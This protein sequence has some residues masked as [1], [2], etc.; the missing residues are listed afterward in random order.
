MKFRFL[1]RPDRFI[2]ALIKRFFDRGQQVKEVVNPPPLGPGELP[3]RLSLTIQEYAVLER[4]YNAQRPHQEP[5]TWRELRADGHEPIPHEPIDAK[6]VCDL[7]NSAYK[8]TPLTYPKDK[9]D[10]A[11]V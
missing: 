6:C 1:D 5:K 10:E 9:K 3:D 2:R 4:F 8:D 7:W 11:E